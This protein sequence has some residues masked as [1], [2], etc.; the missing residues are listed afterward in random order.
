MDPSQLREA[1]KKLPPISLMT[2]IPEVQNAIA[3]LIRSNNDIREFDPDAKDPDLVQAIKE[4][5][6]L[7][8][9]KDK[10]VD[11]TLEVIQEQLGDAAWREMGSNIEEFRQKYAKELYPEANSSANNKGEEEEG[12]FL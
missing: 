2:E 5:E 7:I 11:V 6:D 1:L 9:R 3:H 12:V 10:Q 8:K 4:N